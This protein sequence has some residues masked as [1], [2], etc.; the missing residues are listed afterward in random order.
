M[1]EDQL[2]AVRVGAF[3]IA[4]EEEPQVFLAESV[5]VLARVLALRLVAQLEAASVRSPSRLHEMRSA[6]LEERWADA[7][8]AW[9]EET[10]IPV[11]V[12]DEPL[13]VWSEAALDAD[14]ASFEIRMAPLFAEP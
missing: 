14:Q 10:G 2:Q 8:V 12:Y 1:A 13:T 7:L 5:D 4:R 9:I 11:D 6:L 3:A